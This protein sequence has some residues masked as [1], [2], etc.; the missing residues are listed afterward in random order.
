M[1]T[2]C[3]QPY[4]REEA[5]DTEIS[6]LLKPFTLRADWADQMLALLADEKKQSANTAA[7]LAAQK[8]LE[9]EKIN[10]RLKKLLDSFLDDL[11]DRET[12]AAEKAKLMSQKKTLEEQKERLIAG[13]AD[14]LEPFQSWILTAKTTGEIAVTGSL[15][16][17]KGLALE[18]F[19]SNLV[20]DCKKARGCCV[21]P[22]SLLVEKSQTG[23]M[24]GVTG[25]EP[26]TFRV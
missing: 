25:L 24:V 26:V 9:I 4:I 3:E 10:L 14:W 7:Q 20:L 23:G 6:A 16:D 5:L 8:R 2:S 15:E 1:F 17:K 11:V 22:W 19:G 13:R 12:F 21:K 18:I